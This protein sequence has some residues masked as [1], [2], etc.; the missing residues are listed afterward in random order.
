[1]GRSLCCRVGLWMGRGW[2]AWKMVER[3]RGGI[4]ETTLL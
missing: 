4:D 3:F 1:M 2:E